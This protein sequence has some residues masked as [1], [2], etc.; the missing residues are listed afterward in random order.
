ESGLHSCQPIGGP[1]LTSSTGSLAFNFG[2]VKRRR[3]GLADLAMS[4]SGSKDRL[5]GH[6]IFDW[7]LQIQTSPT[8]TFL[9]SILLLPSNVIV[10]GPPVCSA[11][12]FTIHLPPFVLAET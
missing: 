12:R 11:G 2:T 6:S 1:A 9:S 10:S 8:R 4:S 7:P 3:F 5:K